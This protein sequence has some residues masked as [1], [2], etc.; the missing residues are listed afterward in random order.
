VRAR[1]LAIATRCDLTRAHSRLKGGLL[2]SYLFDLDF[3]STGVLNESIEGARA[4]SANQGVSYHAE[5]AGNFG[6][7][8]HTLTSRLSYSVDAARVGNL[9]RYLNHSCEPVL[10]TRAVCASSA[11]FSLGD[12]R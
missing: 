9:S 8:Y 11:T 7:R 4:V 2:A 5:C 6:S 3:A 10:Y 12:T 1:N